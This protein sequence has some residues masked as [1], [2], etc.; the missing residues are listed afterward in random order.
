MDRERSNLEISDLGQREEAM[1]LP[2]PASNEGLSQGL[3]S[4][5]H[6]LREIKSSPSPSPDGSQV[7]LSFKDLCVILC[8]NV[9][10][11]SRSCAVSFLQS[12][13]RGTGMTEAVLE[14]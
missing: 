6:G 14:T 8:L 4:W 9:S 11:Q 2:T 13:S 1:Y 3:L 7:H 12:K 10:T 5:E